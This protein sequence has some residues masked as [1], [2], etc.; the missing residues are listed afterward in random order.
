MAS[1]PSLPLRTV[2]AALWSGIAE[3]FTRLRGPS[4]IGLAI[5]FVFEIADAALMAKTESPLLQNIP[6]LIRNLL[7]LP[8][9]IAIF[10][11]LISG[12]VAS[13]YSFAISAPRLQRLAFWTIGLW[14]WISVVLPLL[15]ALFPPA[16]G[17]Q[18]VATLSMIILTVAFMIRMVVLFPAIAVDSEAA[19][20]GNALADTRDRSWFILKAYLVT[21]V[22]VMAATALVVVVA[23]SGDVSLISGRSLST[24]I[25]RTVLLSLVGFLIHAAIAVT[26]ARLYGWIGS[27]VKGGAPG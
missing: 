27:Q 17:I 7:L 21:I 26:A 24:V 10:R 5:Y 2:F 9:D 3:V 6:S 20:V 12:E 16:H 19:T 25:P 8:F 13:Q 22:P 11:L 18:V 14:L 23:A 15:M 1:P 4:L